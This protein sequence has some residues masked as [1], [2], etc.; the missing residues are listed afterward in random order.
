MAE[1]EYLIDVVSRIA[2]QGVADVRKRL[3]PDEDWDPV[4]IGLGDEEADII[5][6]PVM[7]TTKDAVVDMLAHIARTNRY[8]A[9]AV[10]NTAWYVELPKGEIDA[11]EASDRTPSTDP[12]RQEAVTILAMDAEVMRLERAL[13]TRRRRKPPRLGPW[14]GGSGGQISG[15]F[16][17]IG[18][19]LR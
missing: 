6:F 18:E 9:I 3:A 17:R 7:A 19:A 14:Q 4:L 11:Y 1:H 5:A 2:K 10:V 12:N 15:R 8:R 16:T 13:I